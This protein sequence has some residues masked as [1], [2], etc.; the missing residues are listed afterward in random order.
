MK[1]P[2]ATRAAVLAA[3]VVISTLA[4]LAVGTLLER[5]LGAS[6]PVDATPI[7]A[8][9]NTDPDDMTVTRPDLMQLGQPRP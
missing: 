1:K 6:S 2:E 5:S 3:G 4:C 9:R 8:A 7:E